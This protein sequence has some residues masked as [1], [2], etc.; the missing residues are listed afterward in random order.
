[1]LAD[2]KTIVYATDL[3]LD[4]KEAFRMAV[5][6]AVKFDARVIFLNVLRPID[7][8]TMKMLEAYD[9]SPVGSMRQIQVQELERLNSE[10]TTRLER[11]LN[12]ELAGRPVLKEPPQAMVLEGEPSEVILDLAEKENADLI[13]MGMHAHSAIGELLLGSVAYKVVHQTRR[14]VML[15]PVK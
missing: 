1:M 11:F 3:G 4:A 10:M 15:V 6:V 8:K 14:P 7:K 12:E 2:I 9:A 5:S 13:V